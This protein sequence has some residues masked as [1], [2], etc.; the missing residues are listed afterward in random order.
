MAKKRSHGEGSIYKLPSGKWHG[1]L[2]IGPKRISYT[3]RTR[4]EVAAWIHK[5]TDQINQGLTYQAAKITVGEYLSNWLANNENNVRP[6]TYKYYQSICETRLRPAFGHIPL[7]D[8]TTDR[9]QATYDHWKQDGI[10]PHVINKAH[11]ILH[12]A[13]QRAEQTGLIVRNVS[14]HARPPKTPQEEMKFWT[15]TQANQFLITARPNR[16]YALYYLALITGMREMELLGLKCQDLDKRN[17]VI[18]I[19]RQ[20]TRSGGK[21]AELKTKAAKRAIKIGEGTLA[22]LNEH[23]KLNIQEMNIAGD[24]WQENDLI[25]TSTI[26]TPLNYKNMIERS[27][28]PLVRAAGVPMIRF[29]DLRHTA[30]SLML[31][32]GVSIFIVSKILGH[33][34]PSITSDIYGHLVPGSMN[35]IGDMMDEMIA[36]IPIKYPILDK[37][38]VK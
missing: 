27:F 38:I 20:L 22:V 23:Y 15:D 18:Y 25:F 6:R 14:T 17:G 7:K 37:K 1:Q 35:G 4:N 33:A 5:T 24:Q 34:R 9:I 30:A 13:L 19:N 16:L 32:R 31:S 26:G 28:K 8:L 29:H 10:S 3:A 36:P 2:S 21:F 12:N 11:T